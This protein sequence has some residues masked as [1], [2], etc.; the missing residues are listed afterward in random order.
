MLDSDWDDYTGSNQSPM[1]LSDM[2]WD[3]AAGNVYVRF[4]ATDQSFASEV[5]TTMIQIPA[6]PEKPASP[7]TVDVTSDSITIQVVDGQEYRIGSSGEW[8]AL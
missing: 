6:R 8:E 7:T 1:K 3:G 5:S 4:A 2:G